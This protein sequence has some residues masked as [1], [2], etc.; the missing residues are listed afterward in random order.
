[1]QMPM[2]KNSIETITIAFGTNYNPVPSIDQGIYLSQKIWGIGVFISQDRDGF[3]W[4]DQ[5][6]LRLHAFLKEPLYR[7]V[8]GEVDVTE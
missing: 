2:L 7:A 5:G 4:R 6:T 8:T 3:R 1:M